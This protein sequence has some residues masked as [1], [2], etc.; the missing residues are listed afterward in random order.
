ME[1]LSYPR[2]VRLVRAMIPRPRSTIH[3]TDKINQ[4]LNNESTLN[5][6]LS[7]FRLYLGME[8]AS[9]ESGV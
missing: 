6:I 7:L 1:K 3:L 4:K 9:G 5:A 2:Y 8:A